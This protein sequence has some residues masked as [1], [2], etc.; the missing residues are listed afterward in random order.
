MSQNLEIKAILD[1]SDLDAKFKKLSST[2]QLTS[3][4]LFNRTVSKTISDY[5]S[6]VSRLNTAFS[7]LQ[8]K[9]IGQQLKG[10][11]ILSQQ[12]KEQTNELRKQLNLTKELARQSSTQAVLS[13]NQNPT[14]KKYGLKAL[15]Q[16]P[17]YATQWAQG[18]SKATQNFIKEMVDAPKNVEN[19]TRTINKLTNEQANLFNTSQRLNNSQSGFGKQIGLLTQLND[20]YGKSVSST[21]HQI[22]SF[23]SELAAA[24]KLNY[25]FGDTDSIK[26]VAANTK[27]LKEKALK[28]KEYLDNEVQMN[29]ASQ[30]ELHSKLRQP[31]QD[32]INQY[33]VFGAQHEITKSLARGEKTYTH[34]DVAG[35]DNAVRLNQESEVLLQNQ[36]KS[37]Q[38]FEKTSL[39]HDKATASS[40]K[41][42]TALNNLGISGNKVSEIFLR[43][44]GKVG[45]WLM[46]TT[47]LFALMGLMKNI[48]QEA[49]NLE[50]AFVGLRKVLDG[51][52]QQIEQN[53]K[54][55]RVFAQTMNSVAGA[56]FKDTIEAVTTAAQAG[57]NFSESLDIA[58][59]ALI[60]VN[61]AELS[62]GDAT[63][64]M[65]ATIRQFNLEAKDSIWI[66]N[67]WNELSNKTGA[68]T[69]DVAEAVTRAGQAFK[70]VGGTLS[71]LGAIAATTVEATGQ[72]GEVIGRMLRTVSVRYSK[73]EGKKTTASVLKPL[74]I[75]V[76]DKQKGQ[77]KNL[78]ETIYEL[79][80]MWGKLSEKQRMNVAVT[81]AGTEQS[82]R[83]KSAIE[84][85]KRAVQAMIDTL[86]SENSALDENAKRTK[87]MK[88]AVAQ[89][90]GALSSFA[91]SK[92]ALMVLGTLST[93]FKGLAITINV[94]LNPAIM[95]LGGALAFLSFTQFAAFGKAL[96]GAI[97]KLAAFLNVLKITT[98]FMLGNPVSLMIV[99]V[100]ALAGAY[101]FVEKS[102]AKSLQNTSDKITSLYNQTN[103]LKNGLNIYLPEYKKGIAPGANIQEK[104]NANRI[105]VNLAESGVEIDKII[106]KYDDVIDRNKKWAA[107]SKE[108]SDALEESNTRKSQIDKI[109]DEME[110]TKTIVN[111]I[112]NIFMGVSQIA[113]SIIN[114]L[115]SGFNAIMNNVKK[116][117]KDFD[118]A[119]PWAKKLDQAT[120][121]YKTL[122]PKT[123]IDDYEKARSLTAKID[124]KNIDAVTKLLNEMQ[125]GV[126]SYKNDAKDKY[127]TSIFDK[128]K[129]QGLDA[130]KDK[131]SYTQL[132]L[133]RDNLNM[134][135]SVMNQKNSVAD[136]VE[137]ETG[138]AKK[139][140]MKLLDDLYKI[141]VA[142]YDKE[143][144]IAKQKYE[145]LK[146]FVDSIYTT[147]F[148][149]LLSAGTTFGEKINNITSGIGKTIVDDL[150]KKLKDQLTIWTIGKAP[151]NPAEELKIVME[152][153]PDSMKEK[154]LEALNAGAVTLGGSIENAIT[155]AMEKLQDVSMIDPATG[156][157]IATGRTREQIMGTVGV[158]KLAEIYGKAQ[159][160][161]LQ[162]YL[163][164]SKMEGLATDVRTSKFDP[165]AVKALEK[166]LGLKVDGIWTSED[167]Q[168]LEKNRMA[169]MANTTALDAAN[170]RNELNKPENG[171]LSD[172]EKMFG[173]DLKTTFKGSD[174]LKGINETFAKGLGWLGDN[175][176]LK[177]TFK[178]LKLPTDLG[179]YGAAAGQGASMSSYIASLTGKDQGQSSMWGAGLGMVGQFFGGPIGGLIG[180][181]LGSLFAGPEQKKDEEIKQAQIEYAKESHVE[182]KQ[183]NRNLTV[184]I[185]KMKPWNILD[186]SYYFSAAKNR[187]LNVA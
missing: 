52:D 34:Q 148:D 96:A 36:A 65:V 25:G 67:Q 39:L 56:S 5:S 68:E 117:A 60:A 123:K 177:D 103:E 100:M 35:V 3:S 92:G 27:M 40:S 122:D 166:Y 99:G 98:A 169:V 24:K 145:K 174:P 113:G 114:F 167:Q 125:F 104:E 58:R 154:M 138:K 63:K 178:G 71:Q 155:K 176:P 141:I 149:N 30:K 139:E 132:R 42:V 43:T 162:E 119:H 183:V 129:T 173:L 73:T 159:S 118:D 66:L 94:L 4:D 86:D 84:N 8:G 140:R 26:G 101:A 90:Q 50:Y 105:K 184:M 121:F 41:L 112:Q 95:A 168:V 158:G 180:G 157:S 179:A 108:V 85:N 57:F 124:D 10:N 53:I 38:N 48:A 120:G 16:G 110:R 69:H 93:I 164:T 127:G 20:N 134:T 49:Y 1:V 17:E 31:V 153:A 128:L 61:V 131:I 172:F 62:S 6:N 29:V 91:S 37:H 130:W 44:A 12:I 28:T 81:M 142:I 152:H 55:T 187:G 146:E 160:G 14:I 135:H 83:F 18:K 186:E 7:S 72:S 161:I 79:S 175:N 75:E 76:Y 19:Y 144:E 9:S 11:P 165:K 15:E 33:D 88:F 87:T 32:L 151:K 78:T 106:K 74:G 64:Y 21:S 59:S 13:R 2:A 47:G 143:F 163:K 89:L 23:E 46:A 22:N 147:I 82:A 182:L 102:A 111:D 171:G 150:T 51:N 136:P 97:P 77:Y 185:D 126:N 133:I 137:D 156:K 54:T 107:I 80:G 45:T 116:F 181:A 109:Y 170:K 70:G 115:S